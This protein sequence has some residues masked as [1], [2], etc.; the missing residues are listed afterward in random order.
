MVD[1]RSFALIKESWIDNFDK[2]HFI[3]YN[4]Y[5]IIVIINKI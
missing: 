1:Y 4:D 3:D 2:N 5:N